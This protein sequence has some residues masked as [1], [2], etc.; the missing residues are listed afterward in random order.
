M[1]IAE[2]FASKKISEEDIKIAYTPCDLVY[3]M[4]GQK[5]GIGQSFHNQ[6]KYF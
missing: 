6:L 5:Q 3:S 2:V 4:K 1:N